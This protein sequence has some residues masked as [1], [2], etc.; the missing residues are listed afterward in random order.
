MRI[1]I[2]DGQKKQRFI[3]LD[4]E[5]I[6]IGREDDND[7]VL[8]VTEISRYHAEILLTDSELTIMDLK[9][10]NGTFVGGEKIESAKIRCGETFR[11]GD[12]E[13]YIVEEKRKSIQELKNV[14]RGELLEKIDLKKIDFEKVNEEE[15]RAKT[16]KVIE[17]IIKERSMEIPS[18]T[19]IEEFIKEI[20][21]ETLGL[22]PLENLIEDPE[23]TEIMVNGKDQ[24]YF[25]RR[26]KLSLYT[27]KFAS[28][29]QVLAAIERIVAPLGRRID[30]STPLVD[31]RLKDGSRVNAIIPPLSM[32]GPVLT[33]RKFSPDLL[34]ISNL[35]DSQSL[36]EPI[37][38]FL[39]I[40]VRAKRNI[41]ISGGT[42][43]GKT[44]LLN[45]LSGFIPE[46]ER[47]ITIEDAAELKLSQEHIVRLE[48]R[49]PNIEGRGEVTIRDL[50]R[51]ALRMR[52]DRIIIGE[53]RGGE[54]LDMLQAMNTGHDGSLTTIHA[55]SCKDALSRLETM[56]LMAGMDLPIRAI[57]EQIASGIE[58]IL[59]LIR[60]SNGE[61]KTQKITEVT[62]IEGESIILEDVFVLQESSGKFKAQGYVPEF[63]RNL[64][65]QGQDINLEIF[66]SG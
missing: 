7:I 15:L 61:R 11:I 23:V 6:R 29:R 49:P 32:V 60:L 12:Y 55:N 39:K 24:I 38:E 31:A 27:R 1:S 56:V 26:G 36:T 22:G 64:L 43:T 66:D 37:A 19:T 48:G 17:S 47:I 54:A 58:I 14:V 28:D 63:I 10:T 4:K 44:T 50:V 5:R 42:G 35:V 20:L 25:E 51:N 65:K 57:R 46:D 18:P 13:L 45:I 30:E 40:C 52:P 9:S 41:L 2:C 53:C 21:D 34:N 62:C 3:S 16:R 33:I 59:Q 8:P